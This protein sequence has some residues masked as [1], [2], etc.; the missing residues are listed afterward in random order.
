[1]ELNDDTSQ[2][3]AQEFDLPE[4]SGDENYGKVSYPKFKTSA[5][6]KLYS[7]RKIHVDPTVSILQDEF[8]QT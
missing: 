2:K 5:S 8:D 3:K 6:D 7:N 1:M 4:D